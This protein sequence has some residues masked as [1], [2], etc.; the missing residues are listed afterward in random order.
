MKKKP[1]PHHSILLFCLFSC[2]IT[3]N[4]NYYQADKVLTPA[5][6]G[7]TWQDLPVIPQL[8]DYAKEILSDGL[9]KGNN[10]NAFSKIGDC[11]TST[12]WYLSDFDLDERYYELGDYAGQFKPVIDYFSGSFGRRSLAATPGFSAASVLSNYWTDYSV[13]ETDEV[14]LTCEYRIHNPAFVLISLGTNDGYNPPSF[15]ENLRE[16]VEITLE[17]SRLPILM[18]KADDVEGNFSINQDIADLA[19]EYEIPLWNFWS[20]IQDLPNHGLVEDGIHLTFYKNDFSDPVSFDY[21]WTQRN[22]TA[23]QVLDVMMQN[24]IKIQEN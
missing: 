18:T 7:M 12:T 4:F 16:I 3:L 9:K 24:I 21:A 2:F 15:K 17:Q 23:M 5:D 8:S 6:L 10:P 22:L 14:P 1:K 11:D 20:V 19:A 13:C